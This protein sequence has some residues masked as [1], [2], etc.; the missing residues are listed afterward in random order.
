MYVC[1]YKGHATEVD[2]QLG[3]CSSMARAANDQADHFAGR[4]V[5]VAVCQ[6]PIHHLTDAY[7]EAMSWYKWLTKMCADWPKDVVPKPANKTL[8]GGRGAAACSRKHHCS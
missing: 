8:Q 1:M 6:S 4:G 5:D 2:V 3:R 7:R